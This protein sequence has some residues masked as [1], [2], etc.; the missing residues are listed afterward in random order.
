M[1]ARVG[2]TASANPDAIVVPANAVVDAGGERGVFLAQEDNTAKFRVVEVGIETDDLA[3]ILSGLSEGDR[4]VT[5]GAAALRDGD[6]FL[7]EGEGDAA[8]G[9]A[10]R[11]SAARGG[12]EGFGGGRQGGG[13]RGGQPGQ[14][15]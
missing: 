13:R 8:V 7:L 15:Q 14:G 1:Y 9:G 11:G 6:R 10:P 3:E 2:V 4:V 5:T 12:R